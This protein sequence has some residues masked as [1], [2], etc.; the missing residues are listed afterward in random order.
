MFQGLAPLPFPGSTGD[1]Y[2][3]YAHFPSIPRVL[4][5]SGYQREVLS[6]F[7]GS[8][9]DYT[10]YLRTIGFKVVSGRDE[11]PEFRKAPRITFDSPSDEVLYRVSQRRIKELQGQQDPYF[12][13]LFS[14]SSHL[15]WKDPPRRKRD[16]QANV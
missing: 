8:L 10:S 1:W 12:L 7:P 4:S 5:D 9:L 11:V 14:A 2:A 13:A 15:P 6:T 3:S 16:V